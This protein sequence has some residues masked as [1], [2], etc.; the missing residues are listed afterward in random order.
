MNPISRMVAVCLVV[1]LT[2]TAAFGSGMAALGAAMVDP[3]VVL[4]NNSDR[5]LIIKW[6]TSL[7]GVA[8]SN[9]EQIVLAPGTR[10]EHVNH[11]NVWFA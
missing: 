1:M 9:V 4:T 3:P 5:A 2:G 6:Q 10:N 11:A 8:A 7:P